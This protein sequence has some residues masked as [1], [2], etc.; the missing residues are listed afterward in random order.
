VKLSHRYI[1]ARS[2]ALWEL[3]YEADRRAGVKVT[4]DGG[5][6]RSDVARCP[7]CG[8]TGEIRYAFRDYS[9]GVHRFSR[10]C[11]ACGW[12]DIKENP[13]S[14]DDAEAS[15]ADELASLLDDDG[16]EE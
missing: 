1:C 14:D 16:D 8:R 12:A 9:T 5:G 3:L 6:R 13:R 4:K 15:D 7:F 11:F 2:P 10:E